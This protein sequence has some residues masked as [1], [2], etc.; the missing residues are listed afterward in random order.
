MIAISASVLIA[1]LGATLDLPSPAAGQ[2]AVAKVMA[3]TT[4]R[5]VRQL[6]DWYA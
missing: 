1:D 3:A 6:G 2:K 5:P 4:G